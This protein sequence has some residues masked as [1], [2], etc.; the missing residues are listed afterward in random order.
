MPRTATDFNLGIGLPIDVD[1]FDAASLTNL[2]HPVSA[3]V[4]IHTAGGVLPPYK[5]LQTNAGQSPED[6]SEVAVFVTVDQASVYYSASTMVSPTGALMVD[7]GKLY[8]QDGFTVAW[9]GR[10]AGDMYEV[11]ALPGGCGDED[12]GEV[13]AGDFP[14]SLEVEV[15]AIAPM[16]GTFSNPFER[17]DFYVTDVNGTSWYVGS[18]MS[19]TSERVGGEEENARWRAWSYSVTLPGAMVG[20]ATRADTS[21]DAVSP[22]DPMI[23]AV[24]VNDEN[25]GLVQASPVDITYG[26]S[27]RNN[28]DPPRAFRLAVNREG[29][30]ERPG[31][32]ALWWARHGR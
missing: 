3:T 8:A 14:T 5:A 12:N 24:A 21:V 9:E 32:S 2:N 7:D 1:G 29:P 26:K 11:C 23:R 19:G 18:D 28:L 27:G 15:R 25:V 30:A 4:G 13:D 31:P 22:V 6:M 20:M 17:V 16:G 10:N